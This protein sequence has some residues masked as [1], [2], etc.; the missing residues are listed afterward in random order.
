MLLKRV[1]GIIKVYNT[2]KDDEKV[3]IAG[4]YI[5]GEEKLIIDW[6][7]M[8]YVEKIDYENANIAERIESLKI[9]KNQN[10]PNKTIDSSVKKTSKPVNDKPIVKNDVGTA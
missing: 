4:R 6:L 1:E 9:Q 3:L 5:Q 2:R 7:N 10:L 8:V